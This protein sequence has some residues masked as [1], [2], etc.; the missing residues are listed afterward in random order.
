MN[1]YSRSVRTNRALKMV[2]AV[3][4]VLLGYHYLK[5]DECSPT[6]TGPF[7]GKILYGCTVKAVATYHKNNVDAALRPSWFNVWAHRFDKSPLLL[8][9]NGT[10]KAITEMLMSMNERF[11]YF[12]TPDLTK[13]N[14]LIAEGQI[15]G[16]GAPFGLK[17]TGDEPQLDLPNYT[18][19]QLKTLL[20]DKLWLNSKI[21]AERQLLV[22]DDP[23]RG[24]PA[25]NANLRAGDQI[26][27]INGTPVEG[28]K[29]QDAIDKIRGSPGTELTLT[30]ESAKDQDHKQIMVH[31]VRQNQV[32]TERDIGDLGL[33]TIQHFANRN[34][35]PDVRE[36][37]NTACGRAPSDASHTHCKAAALI[38]DLRDNPGGLVKNV[39]E[40]SQLFLDHGNLITTFD[41]DGDRMTRE[42]ITLTE[43]EMIANS[44]DSLTKVKRW[45]KPAFPTDRWI[46]VL[47]NEH[48]AS[49]AEM[50]AEI[51]HNKRV[52]IVG[53]RTRGKGVGQCTVEL[54]YQFSMNVICMEYY[55]DGK[56]VDWVGVTPDVIVDQPVDAE[57]DLQ[58]ARAIEIAHNPALAANVTVTEDL[59]TIM[60]ERKKE[61]E[62][63][64]QKARDL[65]HLY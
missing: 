51:L 40:I 4:L 43:N 20:K 50:L 16:I 28:M 38:L 18:T 48:S 60:Q 44:G 64:Q 14:E 3:L 54:P 24:S 17:E 56:S 27:A 25:F 57:E 59:N 35:A 61:F 62:L 10:V 37:V 6:N 22:A 23:D 63:S 52:I 55:A 58:L 29:V 2:L 5:D 9:E 31:L 11:D 15:T 41:R 30:I 47:V 45:S 36:S 53:K 49:A 42:E 1:T 26:I 33:I 34:M 46:V 39:L 21:T 12:Y 13:K 8:T 7:N 19:P 32:V 65:L